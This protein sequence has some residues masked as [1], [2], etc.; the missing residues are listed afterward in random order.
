[1]KSTIN[2]GIHYFKNDDVK[3]VGFSDSNWG[4]NVD[5][6]NFTLENCFNLGFGMIIWSSRK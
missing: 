4:S 5:G 3:L 1:M 6:I 2:V